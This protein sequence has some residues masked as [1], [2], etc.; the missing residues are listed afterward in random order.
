MAKQDLEIVSSA[1][2]FDQIASG[3]RGPGHEYRDAF[4]A[5][6]GRELI[7]GLVNHTMLTEGGNW[8]ATNIDISGLNLE[9][10]ADARLSGQAISL[11]PRFAVKLDVQLAND[12]GH[13]GQL[14]CIKQEVE[15]TGATGAGVDLLMGVTGKIKKALLVPNL[16]L[17]EGINDQLKSRKAV[18]SGAVLL[19]KDGFLLARIVGGPLT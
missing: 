1:P 12:P 19:V 5:V 14:T 4:N 3:L 8:S 18:A 7:L 13:L 2:I 15:L 17:L 16:S 6:N 10:G 11:K 9:I